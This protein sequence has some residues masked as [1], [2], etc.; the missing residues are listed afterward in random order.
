MEFDLNKRHCYWFDALAQIPR[1]SGNEKA[2]SDFI[3]QFAKD[4]G[5]TYKQDHV[6]NVIVDKPASPGYEDAQPLI[7]QAHLDVVCEKRSM[8]SST[9][10]SSAVNT[11]TYVSAL[12]L[13]FRRVPV[14]MGLF[15]MSHA[16]LMI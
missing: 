14:Y 8:I 12:R 11:L 6:W 7:M 5:L 2:A 10:P 16:F 9:N 4:H 13:S 1:G 3:V 15:K